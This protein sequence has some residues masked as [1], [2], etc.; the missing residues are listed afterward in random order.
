MK[1]EMRDS[2]PSEGSGTQRYQTHSEATWRSIS[3]W[4]KENWFHVLLFIGGLALYFLLG[5]FLWWIFQAYVDPSAIQDPSKEATAKKD[6][7]QALGF[8]MAGVAGAIGIYFTW[9]G[10]RIT[11]N[12][13]Q[14]T[15]HAQ[16][17]N[18]RNT[19]A[20]LKNAQKELDITH[21]GQIT[22][23]FTRAIDQLGNEKPEVRIGGI[24]ALESIAKESKEHYWP[25]IEILASYLQTRAKSSL[26]DAEISKSSWEEDDED[27][28]HQHPFP[29]AQAALYV[30]ARRDHNLD[31]TDGRF[32]NLSSTDL[33]NADLRGANLRGARLRQVKLNGAILRDVAFE[34][35]VLSGASLEKAKLERA[36]FT[37]ANLRKA[38]LRKADLEEADFTEAN[39]RSADLS[40]AEKLKQ[41][42][43]NVAF[44]SNETKLSDHLKHPAAWTKP[45]EEQEREASLKKGRF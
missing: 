26:V 33:R 41:E 37:K 29:D 10:Q 18:Q 4:F 23:R 44:G 3:K 1:P 7:L 17:Q 9:R 45:L 22:E 19:L 34:E 13:L 20:Q 31:P 21:R 32:I 24:Y 15:Q 36:T 14:L 27:R 11:K 38:Q 40:G 12:N 39:L 8:I 25:I 28:R 2:A 30:L 35:A 5:L 42:Q 43:I 16:E 6:L